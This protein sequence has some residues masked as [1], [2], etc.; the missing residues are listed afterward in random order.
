MRLHGR[1]SLAQSHLSNIPNMDP[2]NVFVICGMP[3][4]AFSV[5]GTQHQLSKLDANK[6][7]G[8]DNIS[9]YIL[10]HCANEISSVLQVIFIQ[11]L[12]TCTLLSDCLQ[13]N[14]CSVL[15]VLV[16]PTIGLYH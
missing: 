6:A 7:K 13:A 15:T 11:S 9:P 12:N 3:G 2:T 5:D 8:T 14:I 4:I 1:F 10:K 16:L